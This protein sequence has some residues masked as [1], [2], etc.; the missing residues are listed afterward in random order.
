MKCNKCGGTKFAKWSQMNFHDGIGY[1]EKKC[2]KC[3]WPVI[4]KA[5]Y[6][7]PADFREALK[8]MVVELLAEIHKEKDNERY[9]ETT[10]RV[11]PQNPRG[12]QTPTGERHS[13][14]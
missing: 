3:N 1:F 10:M 8:K 5:E 13:T 11:R 2:N 14:S 4:E 9:N 6:Y 7:R 12:S